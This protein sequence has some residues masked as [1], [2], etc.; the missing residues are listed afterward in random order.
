MGLTPR[1]DRAYAQE[2][3]DLHAGGEDRIGQRR[4]AACADD[5]PWPVIIASAVP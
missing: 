2:L 4:P 1:M 3:A 5:A